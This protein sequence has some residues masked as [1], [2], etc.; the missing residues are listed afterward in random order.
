M[1]SESTRFFGQPRLTKAKVLFAGRLIRH[2]PGL[3]IVGTPW[4]IAEYGNGRQVKGRWGEVTGVFFSRRLEY[5]PGSRFLESKDEPGCR[6]VQGAGPASFP[7]H[8]RH[9]R[10]P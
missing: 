4:V 8:H 1:R 9:R 3:R 7:R 5:L 10:Q 6:F 2:W